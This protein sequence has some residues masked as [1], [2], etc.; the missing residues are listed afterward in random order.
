MR[1]PEGEKKGD[2]DLT[3]SAKLMEAAFPGRMPLLFNAPLAYRPILTG[4]IEIEKEEHL[5]LLVLDR[6]RYEPIINVL[7][8][9]SESP[10][11][12]PRYVARQ[13]G[14]SPTGEPGEILASSGINWRSNHFAEIYVHTKTPYRRQGLGKSVAAAL[15]GEILESG[16]RPLYSVN[17][18][19]AASIQLAES[20][21]FVDIGIR[22]IFLE[23]FR[24]QLPSLHQA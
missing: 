6:G 16:R 10:D 11:G 13:T 8:S 9:R 15:V 20:V 22:E 12:L 19:N 18:T 21:G 14:A 17:D 4:L 5:R 7:I 3:S 24:K 23:G 1:L 2:P